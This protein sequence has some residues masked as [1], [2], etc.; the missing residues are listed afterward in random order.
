MSKK[1]WLR[2]LLFGLPCGALVWFFYSAEPVVAD[3]SGLVTFLAVGGAVA[4]YSEWSDRRW[5]TWVKTTCA[6]YEPEGVVHWGR[7]WMPRGATRSIEGLL[8]LT[9]QRLMFEPYG[10]N[11]FA[12]RS[13]IPA[14]EIAGARRGDGL[15][16]NAVTLHTR[17]RRSLEIL[18]ERRDEW[19]AKLP[20]ARG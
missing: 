17:D 16:K 14:A 12:K 11:L 15:H 7:A 19:L 6:K 13:E 8:V 2:G 18:V 5:A 10:L 4:S 9:T 1:S 3:A 20:G